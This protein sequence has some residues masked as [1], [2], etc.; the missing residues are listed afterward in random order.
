MP[1]TDI[2]L[3][4]LIFAALILLTGFLARVEGL[5]DKLEKRIQNLENRK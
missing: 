4:S 2:I 5:I 1:V 3:Y